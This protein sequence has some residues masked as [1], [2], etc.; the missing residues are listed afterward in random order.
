MVSGR[1]IIPDGLKFWRENRQTDRQLKRKKNWKI[2]NRMSM[3]KYKMNQKNPHHQQRPV[4]H[5]EKATHTT[6]PIRLN[7]L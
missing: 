1:T 2:E 4:L 3:P 6:D 7:W 5:R